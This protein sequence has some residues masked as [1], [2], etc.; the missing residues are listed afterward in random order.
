MAATCGNRQLGDLSTLAFQLA[1]PLICGLVY[2]ENHWAVLAA[3]R[4][5]GS[6]MVYDSLPNQT[7]YDHACA[8]LTHLQEQSLMPANVQLLRATVPRQ[9]NNWSCGHR[10]VLAMDAAMEALHE[11]KPLPQ[12]IGDDRISEAHIGCLL[13][14]S[15]RHEALK[16]ERED[17]EQARAGMGGMK[18]V[19][20]PPLGSTGYSTSKDK[21]CC[22][23]SNDPAPSRCTHV[24]NI[25]DGSVAC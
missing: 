17:A 9:T 5:S 8:F 15:Q 23:P 10:S 1:A 20:A 6:A 11:S 24:K 18:C 25:C 16:R 13:Q 12:K 14:S 7:C 4:R 3:S 2:S 21:A 19:K 22:F